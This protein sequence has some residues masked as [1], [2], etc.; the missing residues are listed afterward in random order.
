MYSLWLRSRRITLARVQVM[1]PA[2]SSI[3]K[4]LPSLLSGSR[5]TDSPLF[6]QYYEDAKTAFAL[7]FA[8]PR[9]SASI[10]PY[11]AGLFLRSEC[12][13]ELRNARTLISGRPHPVVTRG[14]VRLSQVS[15]KTSCEFALLSDPGRSESAL[16]IAA[17]RYCSRLG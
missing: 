3:T 2:C 8:F 5:G 7:L 6:N 17:A 10:P 15:V 16:P 1:F 13:Q 4:H 12:R 11:A 9:R 14:S